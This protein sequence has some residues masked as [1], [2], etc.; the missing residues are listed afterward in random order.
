MLQLR[1]RRCR[2]LVVHNIFFFFWVWIGWCVFNFHLVR[3]LHLI[4]YCYR[5]KLSPNKCS[6]FGV[7]TNR[8]VYGVCNFYVLS[9]RTW[10]H[11][12]SVKFNSERKKREK[13]KKTQT[14]ADRIESTMIGQESPKKIFVIKIMEQKRFFS[15]AAAA[16]IFLLE[17][18]WFSFVKRTINYRLQYEFSPCTQKR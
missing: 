11:F 9:E 14:A 6:C 15:T 4:I 13:E 3:V 7:V 12:R 16:R 8:N 5:C 10:D 1:L 2:V 18:L 17:F